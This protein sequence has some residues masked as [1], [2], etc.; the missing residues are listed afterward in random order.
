VKNIRVALG[1]AERGHEPQSFV[2]GLLIRTNSGNLMNKV[3]ALR[4]SLHTSHAQRTPVFESL[5][6]HIFPS[7]IKYLEKY[8][9]TSLWT[10]STSKNENKSL[11]NLTS[12]SLTSMLVRLKTLESKLRLSKHAS[13]TIDFDHKLQDTDPSLLVPFVSLDVEES[14]EF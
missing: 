12:A 2:I 3:T 7:F 4:R 5:S 1:G 6:C 9:R 11:R 14:V 10:I 8:T 13:V